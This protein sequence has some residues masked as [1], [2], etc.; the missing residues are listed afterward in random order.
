MLWVAIVITR[1]GRRCSYTQCVS[2][3]GDISVCRMVSHLHA[4]F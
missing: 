3:V 2:A 1:P 4:A